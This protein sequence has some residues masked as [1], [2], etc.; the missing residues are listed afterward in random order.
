[1]K[2][3][4]SADIEGIGCVVR[5]EHS[6]VQ[7]REYN[8]ARRQMT[9]EVNAAVKGAFAAGAAEVV[10]ADAHNVGL[11]ILPEELDERVQLI[12]GS[13]RPFSMMQGVDLGFDAVM[14]VGYHG[15]SKTLDSNIVH[16]FSGRAARLTINGVDVGEIGLNALL[17]GYYHTPV[18][19]ISGDEQA[20]REAQALMPW[21]GAAVVKKAIGSYAGL[22]LHP[23]KCVDLIAAAAEESLR[24][25]DRCR[26]LVL[27]GAGTVAGAA[28]ELECTTASTAD[29]VARLPRSVRVS[30]TVVR[31]Q[32][33]DVREA[34]QAFC[35]MADLMELTHF[36]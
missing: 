35:A 20:C 29:R 1:M 11:N 8:F 33:Q 14:F 7:G 30:G 15:M 27:P 12:M 18:V 32:A 25:R 21:V 36:I 26:P 19:M 13:P 3:Y 4:I 16:I 17:A 31:Y 22:C 9:A 23:K 28:M 24:H 34:Y 5:S 6:S 10:V 2:V